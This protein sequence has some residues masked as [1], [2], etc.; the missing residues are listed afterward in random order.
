MIPAISIW[1]RFGDE[2]DDALPTPTPT[3]YSQS[4]YS[5]PTTDTTP[6]VE[7]EDEAGVIGF[8]IISFW[9]LRERERE[10]GENPKMMV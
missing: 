2:L 8:D 1:T 10:N 9:G 4:S 6:V 3:R 5:S 7:V